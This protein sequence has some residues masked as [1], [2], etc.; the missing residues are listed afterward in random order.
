MSHDPTR[1]IGELQ[2]L[3]LGIE[4]SY[5]RPLGLRWSPYLWP[6][7]GTGVQVSRKVDVWL[8]RIKEMSEG[9][10]TET[11]SR[12]TCTGPERIKGRKRIPQRVGT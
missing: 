6:V 11:G 2:D 7:I 10:Y 3:L 8:E 4:G 1:V 9:E 12:E 5:S